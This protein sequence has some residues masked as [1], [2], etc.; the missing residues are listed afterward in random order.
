[1]FMPEPSYPLAEYIKAG[2][3][4]I[5]LI[6]TLYPL[7]PTQSKDE[8]EAKIAAAEDALH[9]ANVFLAQQWGYKLHDCTFPPQIMLYDNASKER[10]C[11]H[12]SFKT[13]FNRSLS[14]EDYEDTFLSVRS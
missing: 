3:E 8:V 9:K 1:M 14:A 7:L 2:T 11:P 10:V 12:C 4:A 6:K 5:V 13:N